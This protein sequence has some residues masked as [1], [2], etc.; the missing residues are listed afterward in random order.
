MQGMWSIPVIPA[1]GRR[2][3]EKSTKALEVYSETL[4]Q[5]HKIK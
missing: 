2:R 1:L 4:S 3:R 5:K